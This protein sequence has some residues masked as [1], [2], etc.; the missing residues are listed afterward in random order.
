VKG[1]R[2]TGGRGAASRG[3]ASPATQASASTSAPPATQAA[4][5]ASAPPA[6]QAAAST[7]ASAA[8]QAAAS[9]SAPP[10]TQAAAFTSASPATQAAAS[11]S[12]PPATQAAASTSAPPATQAAAFTSV[13]PESAGAEAFAEL[14]ATFR[15]YHPAEST[16]LLERAYR[17]SEAAHREQRR[18]SGEPYILH[19][20]AVAKILAEA[21]L[22]ATTVATGL[23]HDTVEDTVAT[24]EQIE[25]TFGKDVASLV[26]GLTKIAK[27]SFQTSE[28]KQAENFRK[29]VLAMARDLRVIVIKL[30]DRLHN[31]RTL[32]HV[33]PE[34]QVRIAQ[35]TLDIYSPLANRLGLQAWKRELE[36]LGLRYT[37]PEIY[38][39]LVAQVAKKREAREQYAR[40]VQAMIEQ[41][42][43]SHH[44][45][46][47]I[48]TGRPKHFYSIHKKMERKK[49]TYDQVFDITGF[50]I[51]VATVEQCYG[52]LGL[53]HS[54]WTP[55]P[56]RFKDY[57][58][59]PK[60][61]LYQSLHTTVVGPGGE[62]LEVQIRTKEMHETAERGIAAHWAYKE[63]VSGDT[64]REKFQWLQRLVEWNR[65]LKDNTEF[66]ETVKMDLFPEDVYIFTPKGQVLEFPA[67][68]T[69]LDFAYSI[70]TDLGHRCIG[71][72]V[73][74][75]MVSLKHKLKSGDTVEIVTSPHQTPNKDWL[76]IVKTSRAKSK[77]RAFIKA[78]EQASS[79][80][81]GQAILERELKREQLSFAALLKDGTLQKVAEQFSLKSADD[82]LSSV[83]YG[84]ISPKKV[85]T[86]LQPLVGTA[87]GSASGATA[88]APAKDAPAPQA[89]GLS[90]IFENAS[91]QQAREQT[92]V[93]VKG[94]EDL[95]VRFARCC[96]PVLGDPVVGFITRGR[97]ITVHNKRCPKV[98][99]SDPNRIVDIEWDPTTPAERTVKVT[100]IAEDRPGL[101]ADLSQA[102]RDNRANITRAQIGTTKDR[103]AVCNF[104]IA[105]R[106]L[107]QLR[108]ILSS[109]EALPGVIRAE[110]VQ[111]GS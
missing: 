48:V 85:L 57:I 53:I 34:K 17:F 109:L 5:S 96:S 39:K 51:I 103:K 37:R 64:A 45:H 40:D 72:K 102:I 77:I 61:N 43:E 67:G 22:D 81:M 15:K 23:L 36:D 33:P 88:P 20:I 92:P 69:P 41:A 13:S 50:R 65:D 28:E 59:I 21:Q 104:T 82:L 79:R 42:L 66:L 83:G 60:A 101:L 68:A 38:Y 90:R 94:I 35:E 6:T 1:G 84:K 16:E 9:T 63:G 54:L 29:M 7:S 31:M 49:L 52:V 86:R 111:R 106:D 107:S 25:Q 47:A 55:V 100:V 27:I 2:Q 98:I 19:P 80:Q 62:K 18:S 99:G 71:A 70:H 78:Q 12:A 46:G 30:A 75:R 93:T 14:L 73:N 56:G 110:R 97:G 4:A 10:A 11:T 26:D 32:Q 87:P 89:P 95:L 3:S 44:Y 24:L 74:A 76:K 58:A 105:I 91:K 108:K 8:T